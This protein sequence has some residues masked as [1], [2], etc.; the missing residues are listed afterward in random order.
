MKDTITILKCNTENSATKTFSTNA[1]GLINKISYNA[2]CWFTHESRSIS[3]LADLKAVLVEL[4]N[5]PNKFVIRGEAKP[6]SP[7]TVR[8]TCRDENAAFISKARCWLMADFDSIEIPDHLDASK[9]PVQVVEWVLH[10]LPQCFS[11]A[12]CIYQF[13]SSQNIPKIIGG[14]YPRVA[15]LHLWFICDD[16]VCDEEWRRYFKNNAYGVDKS[17]FNP[18]QPHFTANPIF[19]GMDDPLPNRMGIYHNE[20]ETVKTPTFP[21]PEAKKL[22]EF[23]PIASPVIESQRSA[24]FNLLLPFYPTTG[25]RRDFCAALSGVMYRG[26]WEE[27][28]ICEFINELAVMAGDEEAFN[29]QEN[30]FYVCDAIASDRPTFGIPTLKEKFG[31]NKIDELLPLLGIE[32]PDPKSMIDRL[33]T[34]SL[35]LEIETV[36]KMLIPLSVTEQQLHIEDISKAVSRTKGSITKIFRELKSQSATEPSDRALVLA[37]QIYNDEFNGGEHLIFMSGA[38]WMYNGRYWEVIEPSYIKSL[39]ISLVLEEGAVSSL[40][41]Q[42]ISILEGLAHGSGDPLFM[43]TEPPSATNCLNGEIWFNQDGSYELRPHKASSGFRHCL[44]VEFKP[45]AT[46]PKFEKAMLEIFSK[47]SCPSEMVRHYNEIMGYTMQPWRGRACIFLFYGEAHS[48][49]SQGAMSTI[50]HLLGSQ[51]IMDTRLNDLERNPF[52]LGSLAGKLAIVDD[53][54]DEGTCLAD[55]FLKKIS[56]A[57]PFTA[58]K[59]H[60]DP[61]NFVCRANPFLISNHYPS[62]RDLSNGI[63]RRIHVVPFNRKFT[64]DEKIDGYF[65]AIWAEEG[66]GILNLALQGFQRLKERGDFKDPLDCISAKQDWFKLSNALSNFIDDHCIQQLEKKQSLDEFYRVF[67]DWCKDAGVSNVPKKSTIQQRLEK[68][69][70]KVTNH[71][72][73]FHVHGLYAPNWM[74]R[75]VATRSDGV[76]RNSP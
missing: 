61:F 43:L 26:G 17:L 70:F 64:M 12:S 35:S 65:D 6:E 47:S 36:L 7:E 27:G 74:D 53:D 32:R 69:G 51:A 58:D 73:Y 25:S 66:A 40:M 24:A 15:R 14:D 10:K 19:I 44:D 38:F 9:N 46:A 57:K 67:R 72:G 39:L 8:R 4:S 20:F 42:A 2:G 63:L 60:K 50:R 34:R 52:M 62:T 1:E 16:Y 76:L 3:N 23:N 11:K 18:V 41:N 45:E 49:K 48:G 22:G 37:Q 29:R 30:V 59:K 21:A 71:S 13:S 33:T 31:F 28:N 5:E 54:M 68:I 56:E 75:F 55:G